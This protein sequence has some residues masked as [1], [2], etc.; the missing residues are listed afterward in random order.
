MRQSFSLIPHLT[1]LLLSSPLPLSFSFRCFVCTLYSCVFAFLLP[2]F[3][4][5]NAGM[6]HNSISRDQS[7]NPKQDE[8]CHVLL[9]FCSVLFCFVLLFIYLFIYLCYVSFVSVYP[10]PPQPN[11]SI[12]IFS[13]FTLFSVSFGIHV[14]IFMYVQYGSN[15]VV[16]FFLHHQYHTHTHT[17]RWEKQCKF[18]V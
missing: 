4:T 15:G 1:S 17:H 8:G 14:C 3:K 6:Y 18:D 10:V 7:W 9:L 13:L 12:S 16:P 5:M 2:I 11:E